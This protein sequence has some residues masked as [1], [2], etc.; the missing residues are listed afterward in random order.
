MVEINK[1][2]GTHLLLYYKRENLEGPF[3]NVLEKRLGVSE[4]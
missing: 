3:R 2:G 1:L 4:L